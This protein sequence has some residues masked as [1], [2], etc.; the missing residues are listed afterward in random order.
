[1]KQTDSYDVV[2]GIH[3]V[4]ELLHHYP[5]RLVQVFVQDA[6][7]KNVRKKT[8]YRRLEE[9][10]IPRQL[11]SKKTLE[12]IAGSSSH[13]GF[14]AYIKKRRFTHLKDFF[15]Q[16]KQEKTS[17]VLI[18]DHIQDP[19]NVGAIFRSAECFGVSGV[20]FSEQTGPS[21]TPSLSKVSS[22]ASEH[23]TLVQTARLAAAVDGLKDEG[24]TI[25]SAAVDSGSTDFWQVPK[26][27]K[28]ALI[29]G[30]EGEGISPLLKKKSDH[31]VYIPMKGKVHSLNV[32]A[33]AAVLISQLSR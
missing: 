29:L 8:L 25:L 2:M 17:L 24:F 30:S 11:V 5:Q 21:L 12:E 7:K 26:K 23:L 31:L 19:H 3:C 9:K 14:V 20:L 1:M 18:L 33:A 15:Q 16:M 27:N 13:Q 22:G 28:T 6:M 32:S 10:R 4:S